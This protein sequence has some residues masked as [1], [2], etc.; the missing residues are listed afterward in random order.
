MLH[1]ASMSAPTPPP[2]VDPTPTVPHVPYGGA[3]EPADVAAASAPI[4]PAGV[5]KGVGQVAVQWGIRAIIVLVIRA[6]FRA[7]FK[8]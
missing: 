6:I 2:P 5:A 3:V 4:T 8:G 7:I 1:T